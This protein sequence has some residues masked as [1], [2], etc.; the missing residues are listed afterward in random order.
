[1]A[2]VS[3][4][5][6]QGLR[7][8]RTI[9]VEGI[10]LGGTAILL[11][12]L[13]IYP[14][15]FLLYGSLTKNGS[16]SL[17]N[18]IVAFSSRTYYSALLNSVWLGL[19]CAIVAVVV[20]APMAW[21]VGRTTMPGK[22]LVR[23]LA[24]ISYMTP[25]FLTAIAYVSLLSP[26]A[27]LINRLSAAAVGEERGPFNI[28]SLWG[29]IFVTSTHVFPYV[30]MLTS[31]ALESVDASLEESA[32]MLGSGRI[33]T[34]L[35]IT[36]PLVTPAILSG[37]LMAF[38]NA[39]ALFG[40]QAILGLPARIYTLPTRIYALFNYPPKYELASALSMLLIGLTVG[41][42][43]RERAAERGATYLPLHDLM[44]QADIVSIHLRLTE[45]TR[46]IIGPAE[47]ALMKPTA[48]LINTA[49]AAITDEAALVKALQERRIAGA[50]LDVFMEEPLPQDSP[51]VK[52]DNVVLSPHTG[53]TTAEVFERF[54]S[55]AIA[56]VE[57]YLAGNPTQMLNPEVWEG[58][59]R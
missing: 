5:I 51:L 27:G 54:V 28:F 14:L 30:F 17:E 13:V 24:Y 25:P 11:L 44:Q 34:A 36:L 38:V 58:Q 46:G 47:I 6:D 31:T 26:N 43:T 41:S 37:A 48:I 45:E 49:R 1:L 21:A 3:H 56:N 10:V 15:V 35:N 33:R 20:G 40:S 16:L 50:G 59:R 42:L 29:M 52:L 12:L 18:F 4:A 22:G 55:T 2:A 32:Q 23:M 8:G 19:G 39:I 53:W 7:R 9:P 57:N